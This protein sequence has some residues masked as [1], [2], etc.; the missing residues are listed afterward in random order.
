MPGRLHYPLYLLVLFIIGFSFLEIY[1][2]QVKPKV[3]LLVFTGKRLSP[4]PMATWALRDAFSGFKPKP[5]KYRLSLGDNPVSKTVNQHSFISTPELTIAKP[6]NTIRIVF[7]GESSTAGTGINLADEETWPYKTIQII[8]D[9]LPNQNIQFINAAVGGY[10]SFESYGRLWS[11]VRFFQPDYIVVNH[12]W[13]EMYYFK[14]EDNLL[15]LNTDDNGDWDL[16]KP[17]YKMA[18][19]QPHFLD[20][21]LSWSQLLTHLRIKFANPIAATGEVKPITTPTPLK[22]TFGK[23]GLP[24]YQTNLKLIKSAAE[25]FG[26]ELFVIKQPTLIVSNLPEKEKKRCGYHLHGFDHAAHVAA[27]D[28]IYA[29]IEAEIPADHI[30]DLTP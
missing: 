11:R 14:D 8:K 13:N 24:V 6:A 15:E 28:A 19:Y 27:Y 22:T 30:M 5:G 26:A 18:M 21:Y 9:K 17:R 29:V 1:V 10:T 2:R 3:D 25:I 23:K 4:S 20:P 7:L 16:E 12:G